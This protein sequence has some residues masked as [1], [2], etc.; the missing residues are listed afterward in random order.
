[1]SWKDKLAN[2]STSAVIPKEPIRI[3]PSADPV[4]GWK[5]KLTDKQSGSYNPANEPIIHRIDVNNEKD[6]PTLGG[7][8][9]PPP[10]KK[11]T[12]TGFATLAREWAVKAKEDKERETMEE[13]RRQQVEFAYNYNTQKLNAINS[14]LMNM[15]EQR[16]YYSSYREESDTESDNEEDYSIA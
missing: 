12:P 13:A 3:Q 15:T 4:G 10:V 8:P 16:N 1:M 5:R 2:K 6:F 7:A 9:V 11:D 14:S